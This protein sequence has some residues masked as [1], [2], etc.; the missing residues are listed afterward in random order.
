MTLYKSAYADFQVL[1][2]GESIVYH[3]ATGVEIGRTKELVAQFGEHGGTFTSENPLTGA[4]EE[5]A[6]IHGHFFDS[7]A[8]QEKLGWNDDER[9]SVE[10]AIEKIARE[11]PFLVM[12]VEYEIAPA[13]KPWPTYDEMN[14]DGVL[15]WASKLG[16]IGEALTYEQ[17]NKQ[18][19]VLIANLEETLA[20]QY[21]DES[22]DDAVPV[23]E[24]ITL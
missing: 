10:Y 1:A 20:R 21:A 3:P 4:L 5:Q 12:K 6:L 15:E 11:Q 8:A 23:P 22:R 13:P 2:R 16:L 24:A 7:V 14:A 9:T 19:K 18:R 17:E